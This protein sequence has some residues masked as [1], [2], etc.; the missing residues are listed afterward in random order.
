MDLYTGYNTYVDV[1]YD[2]HNPQQPSPFHYAYDPTIHVGCG[3]VK[4]DG[5]WIIEFGVEC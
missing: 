4:R 3:A 1:P 2:F 5:K